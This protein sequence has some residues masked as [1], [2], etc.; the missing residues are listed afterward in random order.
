MPLFAFCT[1]ILSVICAAALSVW[2]LSSVGAL[3][4]AAALPVFLIAAFTARRWLG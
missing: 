2:L 1:L 4:F 3:A